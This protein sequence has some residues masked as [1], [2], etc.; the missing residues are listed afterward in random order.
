MHKTVAVVNSASF[1]SG[2]GRYANF[3]YEALRPNSLLLN[4]RM[5]KNVIFDRGETINGISPPISN[6]WFINSLLY[7]QVFNRKLKRKEKDA[8]IHYSSIV[9][10]PLKDSIATIHDLF[11]LKFDDNFF[12]NRWLTDNLK[13]YRKL[14]DVITDSNYVKKHLIDNGFEGRITRIYPPVSDDFAHI[15]DKKKI[16]DQLGLP[17]EKILILVVATK[18]KRKNLKILEQLK[19]DDGFRIVSVGCTV[20]DSITFRNVD[21]EKLNLIYNACDLLLSPSLDEGFGFPVIEAMKVGLPVVASDIEIYNETTM[22]K[23]VLV[24]TSNA[25]SIK[26]GIKEAL[27]NIESLSIEGRTL[28]L[29]YSFQNFRKEILDFYENIL[30]DLL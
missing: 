9:G 27:S 29:K 11:F 12:Y 17:H 15:E 2:I 1:N 19:L 24:D 21:G 22:G 4:L 28:A 6:G 20:K 10:K 7:D 18:D 14:E 5:D 16:R 26:V 13:Y 3:L 25:N 23:A 30:H 8:V